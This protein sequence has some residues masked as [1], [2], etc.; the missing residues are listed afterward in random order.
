MTV[1]RSSCCILVLSGILYASGRGH[2]CW[3]AW[4][5]RP[6]Q[7]IFL[8]FVDLRG[9]LTAGRFEIWWRMGQLSGE[10][11][12]CGTR[13]FQG[14][15]PDISKKRQLKTLTYSQD[16]LKPFIVVMLGHRKCAEE[17]T[18]FGVCGPQDLLLVV[19]GVQC[20]CYGERVISS[21]AVSPLEETAFCPVRQEHDQDFSGL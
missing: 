6:C 15:C 7:F 2:P 14:N 17:G 9:A 3:S 21:G 5:W 20:V 16:P 11:L 19:K 8:F 18:D 12:V 1:A 4:G 10:A 13:K